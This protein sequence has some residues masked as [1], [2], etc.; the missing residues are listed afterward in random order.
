MLLSTSSAL[1]QE[2]ITS[3]NRSMLGVTELA[4]MVKAAETKAL[5][6]SLELVMGA[7]RLDQTPC[8]HP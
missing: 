1:G 3:Q 4:G 6:R 2:L 8:N 5:T 7:F